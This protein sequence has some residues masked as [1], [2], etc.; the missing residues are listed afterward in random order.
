MS[1]NYALAIAGIAVALIPLTGLAD[2]TGITGGSQPQPTIQPSLGLNYIMRT[3]G[4]FQDLGEVTLFAGN[5]APGGWTFANGQLL[6][7]AQNDALFSML[8]TTYGGDGQTTFAVPNLQSRVPIGQGQGPG[9]TNRIIGDTTG[10]EQVQLT[11]ANLPPHVH[12]LPGGGTTASTGSGLPYTN[13]QPSLAMNYLVA[14]QGIFPSRDTGAG[15][16]TDPLLGTVRLSAAP[17]VP[18]GW[19]TAQ[20]QLLP[21]NQ[22]QALFALFGTTY[23]GNGQTTFALPDL[24]G[25]AVIGAGTGPGLTPQTLGQSS[26]V[27]SAPLTEAQLPPHTH[28]LPGG[29]TTGIEGGG[30]IQTNMQPTLGLHYI[31]AEQG[32]FPTRDGGGSAEEPL[33]AQIQLFAGDFAPA[34]WAFCEG[35]L[36]PINQNQALFSLLGTTYG[37]DGRTN[38]ALPDLDSRLAVGMGQGAGLSSWALGQTGGTETNTLTIGQMPA[39][40]HTFTPTPEPTSL[41]LLAAGGL[42][43]AARRRRA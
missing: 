11:V 43:L 25:R 19:T 37:G 22:N 9:L 15:T 34:G 42:A 14:L 30:Q 7:I 40:D 29:G 36:L 20:G 16:S 24:R 8:G 5:F 26:G 17:S 4:V 21:I 10:V 1:R 41:G 23:G 31:I 38:F 27:E 33:L 39:H 3:E 18:N 6:P 32:I 28:T 13:M 2:V 35:Q 12:S